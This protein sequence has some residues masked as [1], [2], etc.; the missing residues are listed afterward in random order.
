MQTAE[1]VAVFNELGSTFAPELRHGEQIVGVAAVE[2]DL[3]DVVHRLAFLLFERRKRVRA[4]SW[5]VGE[6]LLPSCFQRINKLLL[7]LGK[8]LEL[9]LVEMYIAGRL[10]TV[11]VAE[12]VNVARD[13]DG[14]QEKGGSP[15]AS[16]KM[17]LRFHAAKIQSRDMGCQ[18]VL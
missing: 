15:F 17:E 12:I 9:S 14:E 2:V 1:L 16:G 13:H 18:D 4:D 7:P 10:L 3:D 5:L 8:L 6:R 11:L